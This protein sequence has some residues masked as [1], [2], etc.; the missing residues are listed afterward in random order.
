ML[1][2]RRF[3]RCTLYFY[4]ITLINN[5]SNHVCI[6]FAIVSGASRFAQWLKIYLKNQGFSIKVMWVLTLAEHT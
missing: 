2:K 6:S 4:D 3:K 1:P 5:A